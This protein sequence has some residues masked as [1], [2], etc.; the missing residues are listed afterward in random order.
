MMIAIVIMV[1]LAWRRGAIIYINIISRSSLFFEHF[2]FVQTNDFW[3]TLY[4]FSPFVS[5]F[6]VVGYT[7]LLLLILFSLFMLIKI[8]NFVLNYLAG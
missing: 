4:G 5:L 1:M 2:F 7:S 6:S 8:K 3:R